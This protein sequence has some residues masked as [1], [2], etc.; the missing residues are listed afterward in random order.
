MSDQQAKNAVEDLTQKLKTTPE[1]I[2]FEDVMQVIA[3]NFTYSPAT[4]TNG[5]VVNEA[6]T[7]E[8]SCKIF[9]FAHLNNLSEQQ[10]LAC[11]GQ[12]YRDDVLQNPQ[13]NDHANIRSFIKNGWSKV[14]FNSTAL[15]AND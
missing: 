6:G 7:N 4:F 9:A 14:E 15:L 10:T 8:G 11:F 1:S 12:Y 3:E 5:D 13:G 2:T